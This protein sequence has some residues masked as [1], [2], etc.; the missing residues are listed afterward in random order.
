MNKC[1]YCGSEPSIVDIDDMFYVRCINCDKH[2]PYKYVGITKRR[3]IEQWNTENPT[4][5]EKIAE[6]KCVFEYRKKRNH[7]VY[8]IND[9]IIRTR[10]ELARRLRIPQSTIYR[11]FRTSQKSTISIYGKTITRIL[12]KGKKDENTRKSNK[13]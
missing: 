5:E 1:M 9:E 8:K 12:V 4:P 13:I 10:Y 2:N 7:Y 6:E 11:K 3:A